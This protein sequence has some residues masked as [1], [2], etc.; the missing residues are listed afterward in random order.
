MKNYS[1]KKCSLLS[2]AVLVLNSNYAPMTITT[3][4]RA[5]CLFFLDKVDVIESYDDSI[6]SPTRALQ[7]PSIVKVKDYVNYNS[8]N[9]VLS[10]KNILLR[11]K[12]QCQYCAIKSSKLTI[13]HI[14]P[15]E[16]G[17]YDSWDN[18]ITACQDCNRKKGNRTP[19]EARMPLLKY[20]KKPNRIHY[21]QQFIKESQRNWKP[22]LFLEAF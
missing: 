11:D 16:R 13:D 1:T 8:M 12:Q 3:S 10:R 22:Y 17:G 4:K 6:Y 18:L 20:P 19:E 5:I 15:K 14:I 2:R 9:V 7:L 21:F